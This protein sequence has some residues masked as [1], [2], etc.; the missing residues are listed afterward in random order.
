VVW[1]ADLAFDELRESSASLLLIAVVAL[2][3]KD[4]LSMTGVSSL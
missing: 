1:T 2:H 3:D 4:S